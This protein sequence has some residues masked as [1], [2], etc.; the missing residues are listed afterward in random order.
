M[1]EDDKENDI[2]DVRGVN[3]NFIIHKEG[4]ICCRRMANGVYKYTFTVTE[5][6]YNID[7]NYTCET[8]NC[9]YLVTCGI[10]DE[11]Y[12]GKTMSSMRKRHTKHRSDIKANKSGLGMHFFKHAE[13]M[14]IN[15]DT[16]MEDV[17]QHF[18]L[19]IITSADKY[20]KEEWK[21]MEADIM[22]TL[23]TTE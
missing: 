19:C 16:N 7:G 8:N 6:S 11:Q 5:Q 17:M 1:N 10:C 15:M 18:S 4:C 23:K 13:E 3:G 21:D 22:Q 9:I 20:S 12:V 2:S 14:G